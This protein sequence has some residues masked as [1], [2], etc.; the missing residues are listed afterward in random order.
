MRDDHPRYEDVLEA[1]ERIRKW[2]VVE[3][4]LNDLEA[5]VRAALRAL[6]EE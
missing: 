5:R 3:N 6:P 4:H 1:L 2:D